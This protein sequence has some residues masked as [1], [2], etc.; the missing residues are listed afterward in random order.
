MDKKSPKKKAKINHSSSNLVKKM[1]TKLLFQKPSAFGLRRKHL[2]WVLPFLIVTLLSYIF[3]LKDLP[4]PTKLGRYD[5]AQTTKIVDRN[6]KLLYEIF[7][8]QSRKLVKLSDILLSLRQATISIEDKDFYHHQGVNPIGGIL[9]AASQ[10]VLRRQLQ[11][12]STI[13]QQLIKS[14]L[15]TPERTVTRKIKEI[16][17]AFW[18]ERLYSKDQ[19]LEMYLNQVAYGG[20]AW[21]I[22]AASETYFGK[23]VKDLTLGEAALL[24]GL[25][26]GPTLYSPFGAHPEYARERQKEVLRRMVEDGYINKKTADET[27]SVELKYKPQTANIKAPHFVMYVKQLLVDK[28]GERLVE[29]GGLKVTTTLDLPTQEE[30]QKIVATEIAGLKSLNVG[31]GAAVITRPPTGEI[32]AMVGSKDYFASDSGNFNVTTA[33]R[34]PGSSIKPLN[35][36]VGLETR[37]VT[38]AS[39]FLDIPTCFLTEGQ[40]AY[41]PV[42]YDGKFHGPVQMRFALGNSFNIPAVKMMALNGVTDVVAS[43]SALGISTFKDPSRY[44]LSLTLGGGEVTMLDMAKAFAVFANTGIKHDL[45]AILKIEDKNGRILDEYKDPNFIPDTKMPLSY[46]ASILVNGPRVLSPETSFLISHILLDNNARSEAFGPSSFLNIG[47]HAVSVKTG[48]TDDKRD[49]WT[50]G[51][52]PNFLVAAW[53]G[54]NDNSPMNPYLASGI[55]GAAPIWNKIMSSVLQKQPDLWPKQPAGI[56]GSQICSSSGKAPPNQDPNAP[57]KG[58]PTRYEYFIK[59]TIPTET[60]SLKQTIPIDKE[61][62]QPAPPGKT[63]NI[64]MQEHQVLRDMFSTYCIDC[65][66]DKEQPT[67]IR[68]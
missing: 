9:R 46:P 53:V 2:F 29:Q 47:S 62:H 50:I 14:A 19:I 28:Y 7:T 8:G 36:A 22:E 40:K 15:L 18:A 34:Q 31:N 42:N 60:E 23:T 13:T 43:A 30:A 3:I 12:G 52:T 65:S 17:L 68:L 57:D 44:G 26:A 1:R 54:N 10:I 20:T 66:H 38:P 51:Y 48:T 4:S 5:I 39:L 49:N 35:Y 41:C 59:G 45:V 64:E 33:L 61:T 27:S 32:L 63:D 6:G 55:T 25:P 24:A 37:K 67:I 56:I 58:C 11:G 16:I 21:G